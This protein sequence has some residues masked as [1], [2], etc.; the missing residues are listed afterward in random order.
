MDGFGP[1][2][3][4]L[5]SRFL[6]KD[7]VGWRAP[8]LKRPVGDQFSSIQVNFDERRIFPC[9]LEKLLFPTEAIVDLEV[10]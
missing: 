2:F 4:Y 8:G 9:W 7:N 3:F 5:R 1:I 6:A 10:S